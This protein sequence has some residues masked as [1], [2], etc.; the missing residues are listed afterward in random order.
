MFCERVRGLGVQGRLRGECLAS[1]RTHQPKRTPLALSP[2]GSPASQDARAHTHT[3]AICTIAVYTRKNHEW[4]CV[5]TSPRHPTQGPTSCPQAAR[6][7]LL[8]ICIHLTSPGTG[9]P[10]FPSP[11]GLWDY[12]GMKPTSALLNSAEPMSSVKCPLIKGKKREP[13]LCSIWVLGFYL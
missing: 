6:P 1:P 9:S 11:L 8:T 13:G 10:S 7:P 3:G 4:H 2:L 12:S 5:P